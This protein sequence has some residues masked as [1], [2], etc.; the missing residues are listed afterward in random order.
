M[1]RKFCRAQ[2]YL[3]ISYTIATCPHGN[4]KNEILAICVQ[5][6]VEHYSYTWKRS[7]EKIV[8]FG[9]A[10]K[11]LDQLVQGVQHYFVV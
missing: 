7:S 4:H 5:V 9:M 6:I 11:S 1:S 2:W 3:P 8:A 10:S